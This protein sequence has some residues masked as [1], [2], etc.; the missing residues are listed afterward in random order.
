[1][2]WRPLWSAPP[3]PP[4]RSTAGSARLRDTAAPFSAARSAPSRTPPHS[5]YICKWVLCRYP[6]T[7]RL[8]ITIRSCLIWSILAADVQR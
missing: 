2:A 7:A 5:I 4:S 8:G 3:T 6:G 1:L